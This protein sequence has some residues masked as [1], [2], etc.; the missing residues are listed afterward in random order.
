MNTTACKGLRRLS[1]VSLLLIFLFLFTGMTARAQP[2]QLMEEGNAAY[3]NKNY[4]RAIEAYEKILADGFISDAL[5]YNLANAYF[6]TQQLGKAIL[7][8]EK[9]Q[10]LA[11]G[12]Q[13]IKHN[14][15]VA[16]GQQVDEMEPLPAFFLSQWWRG[17]RSRLSTNGWTI[18]GLFLL[19]VS[20]AGFLLW[21]MGKERKRRKQ[22]FLVGIIALA[23]CVLPFALAISRKSYDLHSKEAILLAPEAQL[24][25]A[26]DTDSQ[27]VLTIHEGLKLDLQD[28]ISDWYKV[29]LPNGE[30]GWLPVEVV[31]EI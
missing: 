27:V 29:R 25:F 19:W 30:I 16:Y 2:D 9:A 18:F 24:H 10:Q 15:E 26:P 14:L 12:D 23:L 17:L 6:R 3:A 31:S 28:R 21:L 11:P 13:D 7:H 5:H 8:Y 1:P 22:G 20:A 4:E